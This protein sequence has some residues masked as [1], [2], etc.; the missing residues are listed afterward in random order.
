LFCWA[1]AANGSAKAAANA[2]AAIHRE[3]I[4]IILLNHTARRSRQRALRQGSSNESC[5]F[6]Q[7]AARAHPA[8]IAMS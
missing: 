8:L 2:V 4:M 6:N 3:Y 1:P 7:R 5:R